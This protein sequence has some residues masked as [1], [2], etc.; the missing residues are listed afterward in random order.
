MAILSVGAGTEV[1]LK[2]KKDRVDDALNATMAA[3]DE[4][5]V[6][7]GGLALISAI[8]KVKRPKGES[9]G[10]GHGFTIIEKAC[11]APLSQ[12]VKNSGDN[13][14]EALSKVTD[15]IGYNARNG[16]YVDMI[17]AGIIDP[18]KVVRVALESAASASTMILT[19]ECV[20]YIPNEV[21]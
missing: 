2:E 4:G 15:K 12:I 17:G 7:G 5:V 10:F 6:A 21:K 18:K 20:A 13:P 1:E 14:F 9:E 8:K 19:S 3:I 11:D 16:E